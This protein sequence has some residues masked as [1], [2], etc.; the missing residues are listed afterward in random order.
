MLTLTST[1]SDCQRRD[2]NYH[3]IVFH[4][5]RPTPVGLPFVISLPQSDL[6]YSRLA[7]LAEEFARSVTSL[8]QFN[9]AEN[10]ISMNIIVPN[11]YTVYSALFWYPITLK[12]QIMI[13]LGKFRINPRESVITILFCIHLMFADFQ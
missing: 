1:Y 5:G 7:S 4:G 3:K 12:V 8:R 6:T 13:L 2:W 11:R 9:Y 10:S